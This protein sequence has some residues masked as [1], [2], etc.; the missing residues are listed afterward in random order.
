MAIARIRTRL[1]PRLQRRLCL[2]VVGIWASWTLL[3]WTAPAAQAHRNVEVG[4]YRIVVG[5]THEPPLVGVR[6]AITV[7]ISRD[8]HPIQ[9]AHLSLAL[10]LRYAGRTRRSPLTPTPTPGLYTVDLIPTVRG[11]Y[12]VEVSGKLNGVAIHEMVE[13]EE[14]APATDLQFP[15]TQMEAREFQSA[16]R[17]L[18]AELQSLRAWAL[19]GVGCGA[20]GCIAA[21]ASLLMARRAKAVVSESSSRAPAP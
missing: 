14:V 11:Q 8:Q 16:L 4:A 9:D 1:T 20:L 21:V 12:A 7:D 17:Q 13:P 6:N 3:T 5:W 19:I 18:D 2:G 10:E 15:E